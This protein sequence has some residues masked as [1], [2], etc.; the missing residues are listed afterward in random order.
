MHPAP[1]SWLF[2]PGDEARKLDKIAGCGA[3]AVIIDLEDAVAPERKQIARSMT[4]AFLAQAPQAEGMPPLW[5][6]VN[7]LPSPHCAQDVTAVAPHRPAGLVLPKVEGPGDVEQLGG[8]IDL[9]GLGAATDA[10]E[11][12]AIATETPRGVFRL[13]GFAER[14]TPRLAGL[15]WGAEDLAAAVGSSGNRYADGQF[16]ALFEHVRSL[17][18]LAASGA[19]VAAIETLHANYRDEEGLAVSSARARAEGFTGRLAIHPDQVPII[20]AAFLP[21]ASEIA[22]A[23]RVVDAFAEAGSTGTVGIDGRMI[24]RPHLVQA[25]RLLA[26]AAAFAGQ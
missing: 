14:S 13:G 2:V 11:I 12:L 18:L 3:D 19:G 16:H 9:M 6:R 5:V 24:D 1:R 23:T 20:N 8:L 22:W 15:T 25:Q 7:P 17:A 10:I 4:A 21:T 26:R